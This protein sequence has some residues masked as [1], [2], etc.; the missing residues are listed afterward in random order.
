M[1]VRGP[2]ERRFTCSLLSEKFT[3]LPIA[4]EPRPFSTFSTIVPYV[5]IISCHQLEG[6]NI[7]KNYSVGWLCG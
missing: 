6:M 2:V 1:P 7:P 5:Q 3:R 4:K